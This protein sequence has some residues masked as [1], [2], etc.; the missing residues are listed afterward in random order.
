MYKQFV[1][2]LLSEAVFTRQYGNFETGPIIQSA[3]VCLLVWAIID[4]QEQDS[5]VVFL[6]HP[7]WELHENK[8]RPH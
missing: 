8:L 1:W 5:E 7:L 4:T 3:Y 2:I 6:H